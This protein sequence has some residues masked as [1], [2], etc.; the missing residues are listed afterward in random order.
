MGGEKELGGAFRVGTGTRTRV[1][2]C[3]SWT[4]IWSWLIQVPRVPTDLPGAPSG[5]VGMICAVP[6]RSPQR[7][8]DHE[9]CRRVH[10]FG[11]EDHKA[12]VLW[13]QL[14]ECEGVCG[15]PHSQ[16][17]RGPLLEPQTVASPAALHV[18]MR[19]LHLH[20]SRALLLCLHCLQAPD[21]PYLA[22]CS[23]HAGSRV[24][25]CSETT[26]LE[27]WG[28]TS[29]PRSSGRAGEAAQ[30]PPPAL[31]PPAGDLPLPQ[32]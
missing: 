13:P 19:Q 29:F 22:H 20:G 27:P 16:V 8:G 7:T 31:A 15:A 23:A 2:Q 18:H 14:G 30:R 3:P 6:C 9:Q 11:L 1:R 4:V 17:A 26:A 21:Q 32:P 25:R 24:S 12:T 5:Q 28:T 10:S